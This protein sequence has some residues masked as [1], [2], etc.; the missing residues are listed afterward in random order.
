MLR[1]DFPAHPSQ[2]S[3]TRVFDQYIGQ[4]WET[5]GKFVLHCIL[6]NLDGTSCIDDLMKFFNV[7]DIS[8]CNRGTM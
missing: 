2:M 1:I 6:Q 3:N 8:E 5:R 4:T 7:S